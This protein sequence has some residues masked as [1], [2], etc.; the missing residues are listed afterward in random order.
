MMAGIYLLEVCSHASEPLIFFLN[1]NNC[2][3]R[4]WVENGVADEGS[5]LEMAA[6][7]SFAKVKRLLCNA[8]RF[9]SSGRSGGIKRSH[10]RSL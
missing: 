2:T 1:R 10:K 3:G 6:N 5:V 9:F 7:G 4:Q 8:R